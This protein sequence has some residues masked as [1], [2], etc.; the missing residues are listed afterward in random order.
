MAV[1]LSVTFAV[2]KRKSP[3]DISGQKAF[4]V[5]NPKAGKEDEAAELRS[6][7]ARYFTAPRWTVE[8][9][10]T[11]GK[12]DI[13]AVCRAACEQG[14]SL[15]VSAGGDGT[16][17]G[18]AN[19]LVHSQVPLGILPLGTGNR[20]ARILSVPLKL[21]D[22]VQLL[23]GDHTVIEI[24]ALKVGD[25]YFFS[26]VSV[27]MSPEIMKETKPAQKKRFGR[28]AYI[29]TTVKRS[30]LFHLRRYTLT[31]DGQARRVRA[32]EVLI[33]NTK[34]LEKEDLLFGPPENLSDSQLE[35]YAVTA[36]TLGDYMQLVW[37]L[38]RR[39]GQPAAMLYHWE[40]QH[41][42][43]IDADR[44][45]QL[46]QAD[47][48]VISHTP[49]EIQLVPKAIHVIMPKAAESEP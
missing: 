15:V 49:V 27:G 6:A 35:V 12:E 26:N 34:L 30:S 31:I 19:A 22:A 3:V 36:H 38:F 46:V 5:F 2:N 7:L 16:L 21:D 4:V 28:L 20:L 33:S 37:D 32:S 40:S 9:Y 23:A 45:P 25:R 10:E 13:T 48:E 18:V 17:V 1:T 14:T 41:S 44:T 8:I 11:T 39:P 29:L 42:I 43:C 47:G 24:D